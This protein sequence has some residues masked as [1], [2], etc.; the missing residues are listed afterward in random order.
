LLSK[1]DKMND[2]E[3]GGQR[4]MEEENLFDKFEKT[5]KSSRELDDEPAQ[6]FN[7]VM[8]PSAAED[9]VQENVNDEETENKVP[10]ELEKELELAAEKARHHATQLQLT[11]VEQELKQATEALSNMNLVQ[12]SMEE[13]RQSA[14]TFNTKHQQM[15]VKLA[16]AAIPPGS[17]V[18]DYGDTGSAL[19]AELRTKMVKMYGILVEALDRLESL[20]NENDKKTALTKKLQETAKEMKEREVTLSEENEIQKVT[21][22]KLESDLERLSA[23]NEELEKQVQE[24]PDE[25]VL[26]ELRSKAEKTQ[27]L[28]SASE[29]EFAELQKMI[30]NLQ[31]HTL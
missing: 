15:P 12:K 4:E 5:E 29:E 7:V 1:L 25:H 24:S 14:A 6:G 9:V 16:S 10:G 18:D 22:Q 30:G 8:T 20:E 2:A 23:R 3:A 13:L 11:K 17:S 27:A 26:A 28:F 19:E 31:G 21:I